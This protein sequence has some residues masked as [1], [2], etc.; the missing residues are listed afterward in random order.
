[1]DAKMTLKIRI[2]SHIKTTP[3]CFGT[4]RHHPQ[5]RASVPSQSYMWFSGT[6]TTVV[7]ASVV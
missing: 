1:M 2:K 6:S 3:T 5:G 4:Q 7:T